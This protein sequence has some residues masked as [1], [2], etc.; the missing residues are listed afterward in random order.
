MSWSLMNASLQQHVS[1]K[2][3]QHCPHVTKH[4]QVNNPRPPINVLSNRGR[5]IL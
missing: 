2:R 1:T 3:Q 5:T 4:S